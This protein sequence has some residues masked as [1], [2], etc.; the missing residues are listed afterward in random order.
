MLSGGGQVDVIFQMYRGNEY[1][2]GTYPVQHLNST[3]TFRNSK[4]HSRCQSMKSR[5]IE[6]IKDTS[7]LITMPNP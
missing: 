3:I 2:F 7:K 1:Q 6:I 4:K 5:G